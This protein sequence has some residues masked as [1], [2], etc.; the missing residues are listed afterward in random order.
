MTA[1]GMLAKAVSHALR[2]CTT[3]MTLSIHAK[4]KYSTPTAVTLY[5]IGP[6]RGLNNKCPN[7]HD[8]AGTYLIK[9]LT[10]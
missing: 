8:L 9:A 1:K 10:S 6:Y 5:I 7:E 2:C 4:M 3:R